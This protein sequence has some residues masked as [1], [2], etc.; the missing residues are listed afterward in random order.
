M[1]QG[2]NPALAAAIAAAL[3]YKQP[4]TMIKFFRNNLFKDSK[5]N[6]PSEE[7]NRQFEFG[8]DN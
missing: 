4:L 3:H 2:R 6:F 7:Y 8:I 5:G 1:K